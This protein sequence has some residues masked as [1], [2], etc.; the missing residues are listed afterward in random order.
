[1][2]KRH[3]CEFPLLLRTPGFHGG[4]HFLRV[5]SA[6]NLVSALARLPGRDLTVIQFLDAR[7]SDGKTR[8]YR[9]MMIGGQLYPLH[10]A[11]SS[12]WKIHDH[13]SEMA[14]FAAHRAE[15]AQF[16]SNMAEVL[17]TRAMLALNEV[18]KTLG[19]DYG[20]ID[21]SV[22]KDGEVLLFEANATMA[23]MPPDPDKRWDYR[24]HAVERINRAVVTM[25]LDRVKAVSRGGNRD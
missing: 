21:F 25:L 10:A 22:S 5:E 12:N 18:Q 11:I 16:L 13:N 23:I 24:R 9:V 2:L 8:K 14:D 15:E 4:E 17:G 7:A 1:M 20:G 3:G 6:E 19:L